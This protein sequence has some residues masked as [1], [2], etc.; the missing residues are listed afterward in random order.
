MTIW[1][2]A[3]TPCTQL[4]RATV[5]LAATID[6]EQPDPLLWSEVLE[7]AQQLALLWG[8]EEAEH[9]RSGVAMRVPGAQAIFPA[10]R[11]LQD[12]TEA[13]HRCVQEALS[14]SDRPGNEGV[15]A[16]TTERANRI[17]GSLFQYIVALIP[18]E[19][20]PPL[21]LPAHPPT[22]D[23]CRI[24]LCL[25]LGGRIGC[26]YLRLLLLHFGIRWQ[27]PNVPNAPSSESNAPQI[28]SDAEA[29]F[30]AMP[31]R[32]VAIAVSHQH[33]VRIERYD[34]LCQLL[35]VGAELP[36]L[37]APE[38]SASPLWDEIERWC[39][40]TAAASGTSI[41]GC[42]VV[43]SSEASQL[44]SVHRWL[45][46]CPHAAV[47]SCNQTCL[48]EPLASPGSS[49]PW[50]AEAWL[51]IVAHP[52]FRCEPSVS[53]GLPILPFLHE[54]RRHGERVWRLQALLSV[55]L[56]QIFEL[57]QADV[58]LLEAVRQVRAAGVLD[59][60]DVRE[61]LSGVPV[62][63]R[64]V[65]LARAAMSAD[66]NVLNCEPGRDILLEPVYDPERHAM[67]PCTPLCIEHRR[68]DSM[69]VACRTRAEVHPAS[70]LEETARAEAAAPPPPTV[71][72][73]GC[74]SGHGFWH[75]SEGLASLNRRYVAWVDQARRRGLVLR[76]VA[77]VRLGE[78]PEGA[79]VGGMQFC[80]HNRREEQASRAVVQVGPAMV[81]PRRSPLGSVG[82]GAA[83]VAVH[84][85]R[86]G[87]VPAMAVFVGRGKDVD[88]TAAALLQE[89]LQVA[90]E[91]G[92]KMRRAEG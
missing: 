69:S 56:N 70:F 73:N 35:Q 47:V 21:T 7:A 50:T 8:R 45:H 33:V 67:T 43:D 42:L 91:W 31:V 82:E 51:D 79:N 39:A 57:L 59:S 61:E 12:A 16:T 25:I 32:I 17:V 46:S 53:A 23:T 5:R 13:L 63:E 14:L 24:E 15:L 64:A 72:R 84:Y 40:Q 62:L 74:L 36:S 92:V 11:A 34:T 83:A 55:P 28:A 2:A 22:R 66:G 44:P 87:E 80:R 30:R 4:S 6:S 60:G 85:E 76:F 18:A 48:V 54:R 77:E 26:E 75:R 20:S 81:D 38:P 49:T 3:L 58:S 27:P 68:P 90:R 29:R 71:L 86:Y 65:I 52:R 41:P 78:A 37:Q 9:T 88:S 19:P 1:T 89:T 10:V